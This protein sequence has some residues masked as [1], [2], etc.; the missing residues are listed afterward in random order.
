MTRIDPK[1]DMIRVESEL[2]RNFIDPIWPVTQ[3]EPNQIRT[4]PNSYWPDVDS[5]LKWSELN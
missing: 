4:D 2:T 1:S 5:N 3:N